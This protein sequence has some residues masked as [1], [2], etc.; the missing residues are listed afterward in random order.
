MFIRFIYESNVAI[1]LS[2]SLCKLSCPRMIATERIEQQSKE[3]DD[4]DN[5][6]ED[7]I[8]DDV[9]VVNVKTTTTTTNDTTSDLQTRT[10]PTQQRDEN[11]KNGNQDKFPI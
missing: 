11:V 3:C 1:S 7:G 8:V 4:D 6:I 10:T 5:E 9:E 2:L